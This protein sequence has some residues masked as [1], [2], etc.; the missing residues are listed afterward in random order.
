[1]IERD[2]DRGYVLGVSRWQRGWR[3]MDFRERIIES[4]AKAA[5][6]DICRK[7]IRRLQKLE[8]AP[9]MG[10]DSPLANTWDDICVQVQTEE[11]T[12]WD[13]YEQT[14][15]AT[16][17]ADIQELPWHVQ[18]AIFLQTNQGYKW[19]NENPNASDVPVCDEDVQE[20]IIREYILHAADTYS[21]A[22]IRECLCGSL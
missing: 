13:V 4:V 14:I 7:A 15:R 11:S 8:Q 2:R 19:S 21:N 17:A 3:S 5:C 9:L 10:D 20:Y 1:M 16:I 18:Q 12:I 6:E 22:R